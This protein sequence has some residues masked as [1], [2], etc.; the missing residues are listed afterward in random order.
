MF[1]G[2]RI[3]ED[4]S[5]QDFVGF[6]YSKARS[7]ARA[8]RRHASR[9]ARGRKK[10]SH[11]PHPRTEVYKP[12]EESYLIGGDT[13]VMHPAIARALRAALA[14]KAKDISNSIDRQLLGGLNLYGRW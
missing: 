2:V 5:L 14:D 13:M 3:I 11:R 9:S 7:P 6:D 4:P 8:A 12:K 10:R 1:G